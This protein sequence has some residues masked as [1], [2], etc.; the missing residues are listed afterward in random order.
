MNRSIEV[1]L[2]RLEAASPPVQAPRRS[3]MFSA[4]TDDEQ[5]AKI[6]ALIAAGEAS[7]DDQ[8]WVL[9]PL[10]AG[11]DDW[12]QRQKDFHDTGLWSEAWG[13]KPGEPGCLA[14]PDSAA[15]QGHEQID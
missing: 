1:R 8:F 15:E 4:R 5:E 10:K 6:A 3:H 9:R 13:P 11:A 7:P 12:R 14:P 2:Q